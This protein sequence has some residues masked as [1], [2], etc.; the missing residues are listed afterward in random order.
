M[1]KTR[2]RKS[3]KKWSEK[4]ENNKDALN[5]SKWRKDIAAV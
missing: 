3:I 2:I 5:E 4:K 1:I